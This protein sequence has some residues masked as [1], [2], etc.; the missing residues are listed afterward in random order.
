MARRTSSKLSNAD[1]IKVTRHLD[2]ARA[3]FET[4]SHR[5]VIDAIRVEL[6]I[7]MTR[8][9][10]DGIRRI[11]GYEW[12]CPTPQSVAAA[13]VKRDAVLAKCIADLYD[14]LNI[15]TPDELI[16]LL[17]VDDG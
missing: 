4:T 2:M 15:E 1:L 17:E 6:G 13:K 8:A 10:L 9:N 5:E 11:E 16:E 3:R 14:Q 12:L 7:T